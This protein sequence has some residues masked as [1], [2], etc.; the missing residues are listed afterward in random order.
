MKKQKRKRARTTKAVAAR[1]NVTRKPV[2]ASGLAPGMQAINTY[3]A[4]ANVAASIEFLE[5]TFGFARGVVLADADGQPR[6]AEM[7]HGESV[8][9]LT[10]KGDATSATAGAAAL[11]T[12]VE[13]VDAALDRARK[14][15]AG[16]EEADDKP[17]G[18]RTGTV[19][20]P[21][22]YRWVLATFKKLVPF[23]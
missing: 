15:G 10:R 4:V 2:E 12:Y 1:R 22:G 17:W 3:L 20:D 14:A 18:D 21:D 19:T 23:S 11:Y 9:M 13:D 8:V 16:V 5:R 6:Y 7:R